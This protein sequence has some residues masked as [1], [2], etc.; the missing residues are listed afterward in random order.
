MFLDEALGLDERPAEPVDTTPS[1][2][3]GEVESLHQRM[4]AVVRELVAE[5]G[6]PVVMARAAHEVRTTIGEEVDATKWAG[7]GTFGRFAAKLASEHLQMDTSRPPGWLYDPARHAVPSQGPVVTAP[8]GVPEVAERVH[9]IVGA[10]LLSRTYYESLFDVLATDARLVSE[11]GQTEAERVARDVCASR[12]LPVSRAAVHF[13]LVGFHYS[14][15]DWT[16]SALDGA[17][18]ASAFLD[19]VLRLAADAQMDLTEAENGQ[20]RTWICGVDGGA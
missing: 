3:Q 5:A 19:N 6:E 18:L 2:E 17:A 20:L 10:P 13:I 12:G 11:K 14:G 16:D 7:N 4:E 1:T 8:A 9:R 15:F